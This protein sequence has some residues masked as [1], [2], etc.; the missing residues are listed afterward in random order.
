MN[1]SGTLR[2][3][4]CP[5]FVAW[6]VAFCERGTARCSF[7]FNSHTARC[8]KTACAGPEIEYSRA[9]VVARQPKKP[10]EIDVP[11][12]LPTGPV[13]FKVSNGLNTIVFKVYVR[14]AT[15]QI[16]WPAWSIKIHNGLLRRILAPRLGRYLLRLRMLPIVANENS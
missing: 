2:S 6:A 3:R 15:Y 16:S 10:A 5:R 4:S 12:P 14:E 8:A 13:V 11:G 9:V 7:Q 1:V